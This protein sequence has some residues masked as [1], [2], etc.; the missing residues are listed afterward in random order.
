MKTKF[1]L[2]LIFLKFSAVGQ[3]APPAGITGSTAIHK[4]SSVF[5]SWASSVEIFRASIDISDPNSPLASVGDSSSCLGK[6]N[7]LLV[8]LGDGGEA[9]LSFELP[10]FDG[11]SWDFAVFENSFLNDFLEL[12][13]VEVSSDGQNF[14]RFPASSLSQDTAQ[15]DGFGAV[16]ARK[17]N[18]LAGK[19][20][21][22][23]GT[24]FDLAEMAGIPGL[25]I[26]N[27]SHIKIIDVVGSIN[28]SFGSLDTAGNIINDPWPTAFPSCGFDLESLGVIHSKGFSLE[29]NWTSLKIYPNPTAQVLFLKNENPSNKLE[30]IQIYSLEGICMKNVEILDQQE[31]ISID[32]NGLKSGFY[33]LKLSINDETEIRK[34]QILK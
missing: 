16:D 23:Y 27:I 18:N 21:A 7:G 19:Y 10:I 33:L 22:N 30:K 15:I 17:L 1:F 5:K 26:Q 28:P 14:F 29:E 34:I 2:L 25:D 8:S 9:I 4:D 13:F 20:E 32:L 6:S 31:Q 24:P 11:P 3:Y 12:A